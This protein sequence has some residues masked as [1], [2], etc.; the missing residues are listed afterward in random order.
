[1]K[2]ESYY[3]A[4]MSIS[5]ARAPLDHPMME[6][7]VSQLPIIN[8]L[9]DKT[10][11][12]IW[13]LQTK[14]GN[15]TGIRTFDDPSILMNLSLWESIDPLKEFVYKG[16][17]AILY[18]NA[19]QWFERLAGHVTV[20]WWVPKGYLPTAA[21]GVERLNRLNSEGPSPEAFSF[22]KAFPPPQD[23]NQEPST[24]IAKA[25]ECTSNV[26]ETEVREFHYFLE[27]WMGAKMPYDRA[28]IQ[29]L[30]ESFDPDCVLVSPRGTVEMGEVFRLRL[31]NAYGTSPNIR[32][33]ITDFSLEKQYIPFTLVRYS[34]WR[35]E[36]GQIT[37]RISS[38]LFI[39]VPKS[40]FGVRWRYIHETW[41]TD[42]GPI[43]TQQ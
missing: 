26:Y 37:G 7:F 31:V 28:A 15:S 5:K 40:P 34:E 6:G 4:Q 8:A 17:H 38:V 29:R 35:E 43:Q 12:F 3:L 18:K 39:D 9:A 42:H 30:G 36:L 2:S 1:M 19:R 41:L 24:V 14:E 20:L 27:R 22:Q 32:I 13:R 23:Q 16:P 21:E 33:W 11:G 25:H 10:P